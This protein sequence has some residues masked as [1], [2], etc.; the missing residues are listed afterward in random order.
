MWYVFVLCLTLSLDSA[1]DPAWSGQ[2]GALLSWVSQSRGN[3]DL[4]SDGNT[5]WS[6]VKV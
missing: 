4:S 3:M 2:A 5:T 1:G 6:A